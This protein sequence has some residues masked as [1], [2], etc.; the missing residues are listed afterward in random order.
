[1]QREPTRAAAKHTLAAT[2]SP[3]LRASP[4]ALLSPTQNPTV[5]PPH[6]AKDFPQFAKDMLQWHIKTNGDFL[7]R[8]FPVFCMGWLFE[9]RSW[10][11][12]AYA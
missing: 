6:M 4:I 8:F 10:T 5:L 12:I 11:S 9:W 1:M 2:A 7:V 3:L